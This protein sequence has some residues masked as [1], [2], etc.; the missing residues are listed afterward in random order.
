MEQLATDEHLIAEFRSSITPD[1]YAAS[2]L[3]DWSAI[4]QEVEA[5]SPAIIAVQALAASND[6][7]AAHIASELRREPRALDVLKRL[8]AVGDRVVFSDGRE[9]PSIVP[10]D[11]TA[12]AALS[13]LLVEL[14]VASLLPPTADVRQMLVTAMIASEAPR[15]RFRSRRKLEERIERIIRSATKESHGAGLDVKVVPASL[16]LATSVALRSVDW[17]VLIGGTPRAAVTSTFQARSGGRQQR[18]L[19]LTY[20]ALQDRLR[21]DG[22]DL[23][24]LADGAGIRDT[25]IR[26]L[27]D[28][29]GRVFACLTL[30]QAE[31]G[32]L[33]DVFARLAQPRIAGREP[34]DQVINVALEA[35]SVVAASGLPATLDHAK[36]AI[37]TYVQDHPHEALDL[38]PDASELA[39][40]RLSAVRGC[41]QLLKEFT[42]SHAISVL[43]ELLSVRDRREVD[44]G[45]VLAFDKDVF[46][47]DRVYVTAADRVDVAT[48][49]LTAVRALGQTPNARFALFVVPTITHSEGDAVHRLQY[50]LAVN[51][52]VLDVATLLTMAKVVDDPVDS[53]LRLV[54]AASDLAKVSPFVLTSVAPTRVYYGREIEEATVT[55]T[56]QTNSVA[57]LGGRRI[58]KTSLMK[59]V[60]QSITT[61]GL[62]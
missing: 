40:S 13:E 24:L 61:S 16:H 31:E 26:I 36:L 45:V 1:L 58:G 39:W 54:V 38:K 46:M 51:V 7:S 42:S 60:T 62:V 52:I 22:L 2:D 44:G 21:N 20:P 18:D 59:H 4:D 47:S 41:L 14:R 25:P 17:V 12:L 35:G 5:L 11:A 55:T 19:V 23:V 30:R 43:A 9:L 50:Q 56:I 37:A 8:L 53:L 49:R 32:R 48:I 28:L 10:V 57:I 6:I 15:R 33:A 29:F 34:L 3:V 27:S